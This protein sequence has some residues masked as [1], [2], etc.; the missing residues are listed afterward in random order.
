MDESLYP[1]VAVREALANGFCHRDYSI[2][3]AS[4]GVALFDDRLEVTSSGTLH[5]GLTPEALFGPHESPPWNPII[6]AV[7]YRRCLCCRIPA[8]SWSVLVSCLHERR[9]HGPR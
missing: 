6:A 1:P 2:G 5:L 9:P 3:G 8:R 4:V 7:F